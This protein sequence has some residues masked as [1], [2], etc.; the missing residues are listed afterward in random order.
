MALIK[1]IE[2]T[3]HSITR[4][5]ANHHADQPII[6]VDGLTVTYDSGDALHDVSFSVPRADRLAV[7]GPNGAGKSTLLKVIA[8]VISPDR[9]KV[10]I[11]GVEPG[12]HICI[13]YVQQR[14]QV[15]WN[16]P[17]SVRDVVMMG[18]TGKL[19]LLRRPS[20]ADWQI[21]D[22]ALA[23]VNLTAFAPRQISE[24]SGGQ[25]QRMFIARAL[26]QEAELMLMD[27]PLTGLDANSQEDIFTILQTLRERRVTV[28]VALHDLKMA[29]EHFDSALLLN[30]RLVAYGPPQEIFTT[31]HLTEAYGR[32]FRDRQD[33]LALDDTCCEGEHDH[34]EHSA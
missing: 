15:D 22:R 20:H 23:D 18:R 14:S 2:R 3:E 8:G 34:D 1:E 9:G 27:E 5:H 30:H 7:L 31:E 24:L 32:R 28:L 29:A 21:V 11:F 33:W 6:Q 19:G 16:F 25:Q 10:E 4:H 13:A 17:V 12:E 26:A